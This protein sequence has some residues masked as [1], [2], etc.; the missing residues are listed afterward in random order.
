[1]VGQAHSVLQ[2]S[3]LSATLQTNAFGMCLSRMHF[4]YKALFKRLLGHMFQINGFSQQACTGD[5]R[6]ETTNRE[7]AG[8]TDKTENGF[9]HIFRGLQRG[10][11]EDKRQVWKRFCVKPILPVILPCFFLEGLLLGLGHCGPANP[12]YCWL[13]YSPGAPDGV[14]EQALTM[15]AYNNNQL[16][17]SSGYS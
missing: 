6:I 11:T 4:E 1:M 5:R 7:L 16:T 14:D 2:N 15:L 17:S 9:Q 10:E 8:E 12:N 3:G 13:C